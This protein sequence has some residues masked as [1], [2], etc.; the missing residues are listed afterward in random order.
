MLNQSQQI[1]L[2]KNTIELQHLRLLILSYRDNFKKELE[3]YGD[4]LTLE[5][6]ETLPFVQLKK[7]SEEVEITVGSSHTAEMIPNIYY[8]CIGVLEKLGPT[9][10]MKLHGLQMALMNDTKL[11]SSLI[12]SGLKYGRM[13]YMDPI[14]RVLLYTGQT[15]L[16]LHY[17][18]Q[19]NEEQQK[20]LKENVKESIID[21]FKDL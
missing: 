18:N 5:Y 14:K 1:E 11:K 17:H 9:L 12:E 19:V 8:S 7:L 4:K 16:S 2:I 21:E 15:V 20:I 3:V 13:V 6:L 10:N